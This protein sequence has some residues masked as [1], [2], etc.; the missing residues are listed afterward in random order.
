MPGGG[1]ATTFLI[2][3]RVVK[4]NQKSK[5]K[6]EEVGENLIE[7]CFCWGKE[8]VI[9]FVSFTSALFCLKKNLIKIVLKH[10]YYGGGKFT[11]V[12][13]LSTYP[14]VS[15][16]STNNFEAC[17]SSVFGLE[18]IKHVQSILLVLGLLEVFKSSMVTEDVFFQRQ[19][20][21]SV[22]IGL[23]FVSYF[24]LFKSQFM[25]IDFINL[26]LQQKS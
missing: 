7:V 19:L 21:L 25:K 11:F 6:S 13:R 24:V 15:S 9:L 16:N 3:N 8:E 10:Y 26:F 5:R 14:K 22:E 23:A 12:F 17:L 18:G 20:I 1:S 2:D 4:R